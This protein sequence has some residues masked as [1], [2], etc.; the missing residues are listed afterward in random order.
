MEHFITKQSKEHPYHLF[1]AGVAIYILGAVSFSIWSALAH[2]GQEEVHNIY[3]LIEGLR[4]AFLLTMGFTLI[5][6]YHRARRK[7]TRQ[8]MELSAKLKNDYAKLK[9]QK[10]Q[11][12]DAVR[13]L[14]R[15]NALVTG[16]EERMLELKNEVNALLKEMGRPKRYHL[17]PDD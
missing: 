10:S 13:D 5:M 15:F 6:L 16:R 3:T 9:K 7:C 1:G 14:E 11:L 8:Q 17:T 4:N 12:E 2:Q